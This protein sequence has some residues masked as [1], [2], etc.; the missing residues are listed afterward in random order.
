[1]LHCPMNTTLVVAPLTYQIWLFSLT[2]L[3]S[4]QSALIDGSYSSQ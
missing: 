3:D 2:R 1:M 4:R